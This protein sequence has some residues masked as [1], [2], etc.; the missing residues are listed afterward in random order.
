MLRIVI[1]HS[2]ISH[3]GGSIWNQ[4]HQ[5]T[6]LCTAFKQHPNNSI[7]MLP[8]SR[9]VREYCVQIVGSILIIRHFEYFNYNGLPHFTVLPNAVQFRW[10]AH[11][12]LPQRNIKFL[13]SIEQQTVNIC[14][15]I[16]KW[17]RF[18]SHAERSNF[19]NKTFWKFIW[20]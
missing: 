15:S 19:T 9:T 14:T 17:S 1:A 5:Y 16:S 7:A 13:H 2:I 11:S 20:I 3:F 8:V 10:I 12:I 6:Q 18:D 4:I